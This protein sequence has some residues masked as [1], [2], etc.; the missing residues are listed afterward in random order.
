LLMVC[1]TVLVVCLSL[2]LVFRGRYVTSSGYRSVRFVF[3]PRNR[4]AFT[5]FG[6]A[7]SSVDLGSLAMLVASDPISFDDV[8]RGRSTTQWHINEFG[9]PT[10]AALN[11][12]VASLE[13]SSSRRGLASSCKLD[14]SLV[15][16][17]RVEWWLRLPVTKITGE[18][19]QGLISAV[20]QAITTRVFALASTLPL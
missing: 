19:L 13:A 12:F 5:P 4:V 11:L 10:D 2:Q 15:L 1:T 6:V 20:H 3:Y 9:V 17:W 8:L 18:S 7:S 16:E 14:V